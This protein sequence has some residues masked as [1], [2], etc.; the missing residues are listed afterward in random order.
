MAHVFR[1]HEGNASLNGWDLSEQYDAKSIAAIKDPAGGSASLPITSIPSPFAIFE[2]VRNAFNVV[3]KEDGV[4]LKGGTIYH[5]LVS[6]ALD[7]MEIFFNFRR[8]QEHYEIIQWT[9]SDLK[10]LVEA[11]NFEQLGKTLE[12]YLE[13]DAEGFH[14]DRL[15]SI[16]LLNYKDGPDALNIVGGTSPVSV[17]ASS[18]NDLRFVT[19]YLTNHTAFDPD[20]SSFKTLFERSD[21]FIVYLWALSKQP[22]FAETF[23]EVNDYIQACFSQ[24]ASGELKERLRRMSRND[25]LENY[26]QLVLGGDNK[27]EIIDGLPLYIKGDSKAYIAQNS[28]FRILSDKTLPEDELLPLVLPTSTFTDPDVF[29]TAGAWLSANVVPPYSSESDINNRELPFDGTKYPYLTP[30]DIFEP[31]LLRTPYPTNGSFFFN[32]LSEQKE[33]S[34]LLPL[35]P[36]IFK[37][38]RISDLFGTSA[39]SSREL[40]K[41]EPLVVGSAKVTFRIPIRRGHFVTFE[42]IYYNSRG[43]QPDRK[44][45]TGVIR[46]VAFDLYLFPSFHLK[47]GTGAGPQRVAFIDAEMTGRTDRY[48]LSF[49]RDR[50]SSQIPFRLFIRADKEKGNPLTTQYYKGDNEYDYI[51]VTTPDGASGLVVPLWRE[52]VQGTKRMDFAVDFGTTNT[53]IEYKIDGQIYPFEIGPSDVQSLPFHDFLF[54]GIENIISESDLDYFLEIP[55][56]EFVPLHIGGSRRI[57]F[58]TRTAM[59]RPRV[60]VGRSDEVHAL[61]NAAIGFHYE[62]YTEANH[63]ETVTNLKWTGG[64]NSALMMAF[65]N[66]L[67]MLIRNKV[68]LS[69]GALDQTSITWFYPVSMLPYQ[70]SRLTTIWNE[71]A[72]A[73]ID[74][75][76]HPQSMTESLAP[77][78]YYKN[79]CGVS[80]AVRPV[81][82]MDIGGE[83]TDFVVYAGGKP[84]VLSSVRFAGNSIF[85]DFYG[86]DISHNGFVARYESRVLDAIHSF[87]GIESTYDKIRHR[88]NSADVISFMFSLQDNPQLTDR[89]VSLSSWI[90]E[91]YSMK[92]VL[93]LFYCAEIYYISQILKRHAIATPAYLTVSGTASR[94]LS[95][96]GENE[97]LERLTRYIFNSQ[98]GDTG[99]VELRRVDNPKVVTCKGGL[100]VHAEDRGVQPDKIKDLFSGSARFDKSDRTFDGADA[101]VQAEVLRS[102]RQFID[103]FADIDRHVPFQD[104][105]GI[106]SGRMSDYCAVLLDKDGQYLASMLE[107]RRREAA[108]HEQNPHV[109][110]ALFFY[111]LAGGINALAYKISQE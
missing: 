19:T 33:Y 3:T 90:A 78:F 95:L 77:Y 76:C 79:V 31:Y 57:H 48:R 45:N 20:P 96:I 21:D 16:C 44:K 97:N 62:R 58:P 111:P 85:G 4:G 28:D 7:V 13:Q 84:Q 23:Q 93:L 60:G 89:T 51:Q 55:N 8:L 61:C 110:D 92:F 46:D 73:L 98:L 56:Q 64:E 66:E 71:M 81:V 47:G 14:F 30:D 35:K 75:N 32:G 91:D 37:Y 26:E 42:R 100:S 68:L 34:Y 29:Y 6:N 15:H 94:L 99:V 10:N 103:F 82:S 12:L 18:P 25:Y 9:R 80:S 87:A 63:N 17:C 72:S 27:I 65:F 109:E 11:A 102:Y 106:P 54:P 108:G 5:K 59:C 43:M 22:H 105:F 69:G 49:F 50:D 53:H 52:V 36:A 2:L 67:L 104:Y 41:I 1:F 24:M 40:F 86:S 101:T 70:R 39:L 74:P 38:L 88:Q 83:T 107:E